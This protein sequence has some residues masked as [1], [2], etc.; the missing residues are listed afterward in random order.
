M[1]VPVE[2]MIAAESAVAE[3]DPVPVPVGVPGTESNLIDPVKLPPL[4]E[5]ASDCLRA[6]ARFSRRLRYLERGVLF[7]DSM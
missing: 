3:R 2:L 5:S 6:A 4:R 1:P 7:P